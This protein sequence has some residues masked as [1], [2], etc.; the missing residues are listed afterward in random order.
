MKKMRRLPRQAHHRRAFPDGFLSLRVRAL[1][2]SDRPANRSGRISSSP[3]ASPLA[4]TNP[5]SL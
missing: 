3:S 1:S 2:S 5:S 4:A